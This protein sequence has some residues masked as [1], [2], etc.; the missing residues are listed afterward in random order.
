[1]FQ[2]LKSTSVVFF[3]QHLFGTHLASQA[4]QA[5]GAGFERQAILGG[6]PFAVLAKGGSALL[7]GGW[8]GRKKCRTILSVGAQ[9][10]VLRTW[11]LGRIPEPILPRHRIP[12]DNQ[13]LI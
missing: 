9:G 10:P 6:L 2:A 8:P 12:L 13:Y 7:L 4:P 5:G 3:L 11:V 1:M